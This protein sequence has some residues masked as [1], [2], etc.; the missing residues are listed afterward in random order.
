[1][2]HAL[3]TLLEKLDAARMHYTL[4]RHRP[5]S[6][7]VHVT[8]VGQWIEI[9]VFRD[10]HIEVSRFVGHEDVEGGAELI[11]SIIELGN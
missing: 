1:M 8:V 7:C 10:G 5:D 2:T 4:G 6:V 3:F 9:D 11:D